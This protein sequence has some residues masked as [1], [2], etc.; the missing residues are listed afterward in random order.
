MKKIILILTLAIIKFN[1]IAQQSDNLSKSLSKANFVFDGIIESVEFYAGDKNGNKL[2]KSSI[3]WENG[4]GYYHNADG[5]DARGYS[6]AKIKLYKVLKGNELNQN[7]YA[8]ILTTTEGLQVYYLQN[9]KDTTLNQMNFSTSHNGDFVIMPSMVNFRMIFFSDK[10]SNNQFKVQNNSNV[11][12]YNSNYTADNVDKNQEFISNNDTRFYSSEELNKFLGTVSGLNLNAQPKFKISQKKN[13]DVNEKNQILNKDF[14]YN[15]NLKNY[16]KWLENSNPNNFPKAKTNSALATDLNLQIANQR[17]IG[18]VATPSLQFDI[19]VS[20]NVATSYFDNC[21]I[22]IAY[23]T[24]VFGSSVVA[25]NKISVVRATPYNTLTYIDPQVNLIDQTNN[26]IGMP[27][28]TEFTASSWNRPLVTITPSL[29]LTVSMAIANCTLNANVTYTDVTFTDLFSR[30]TITASANPSVAI[31]YAS[32]AYSGN[33]SNPPCVPIITSFNNNVPAGVNQVLTIVGKNF[34]VGRGSNGALIFK[35]ADKGTTYPPQ[36]G[37]NK[38]GV[39]QYDIIRWTH[40]TIKIKMPGTMDST[41][42]E[43]V[44]P[45]SGKFMVYNRYNY[46]KESSTPLTIDY[47]VTQYPDGGILYPYRKVGLKLAALNNNGYKVQINQNIITALTSQTGAKP[48]IKKALRA[49]TCATGINWFTGNDT[50]ASI[51]NS[52]LCIIDTGN[53]APALMKT[54]PTVR[55]CTTSLGIPVFYLKSFNIRIRLTPTFGPW[56]MDTINAI[57]SGQYDFYSAIS[58]EL[59]HAHGVSHINDSLVDLMWY[60]GYPN[61]YTALG[62]KLVKYSPGAVSAGNY[63]SDSL[64]GALTC[65]ANHFTVLA[66]NC[67]DAIGIKKN[68]NDFFYVTVSPNPSTTFESLKIKFNLNS[69]NNVSINLFDITGKSIYNEDLLAIKD[70]EHLFMPKNIE[71]GIYLLTI[72]IEGKKQSYKIIKQ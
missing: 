59:G 25:N 54:S 50:T 4:A 45:G 69:R 17:I 14:N 16:N 7:E 11:L 41:I 42:S 43:R 27:F 40:D 47:C 36:V 63:V 37:P 3:V 52:N 65:A 24:A 6:L 18:P 61:G 48:A 23:N 22:R 39:Q 15:N 60:Q 29:M 30:Y 72:S 19:L 38:S 13:E 58:H 51:G 8:Y 62:R 28:G 67:E 20:S 32:T 70:E 31:G 49:W 71:S 33:I 64:V 1:L 12:Y 5:S 44:A 21:L 56:N 46:N 66:Q 68:Y 53:I 57:P 9:G 2:P 35:N 55:S 34:G 10:N 26:T